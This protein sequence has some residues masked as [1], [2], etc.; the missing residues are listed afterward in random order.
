MRI[1]LI[2]LILC[3]CAEISIR[4]MVPA[5][6]VIYYRSEF[7][8][9]WQQ[10]FARKNPELAVFGPFGCGNPCTVTYNIGGLI[11]AF[12]SMANMI[13][14]KGIGLNIDGTCI[15]ACVRM[16]DLARPYACITPRAEFWVH[17]AYRID[18]GERF[19][20]PSSDDINAWV[21][22]KGGYPTD[23]YL[24]IGYEDAQRFWPKC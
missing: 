4:I 17:K 5:G 23:D 20:P 9:A 13:W 14:L 24:K 2:R 18:N 3:L 6:V 16:A 19:D 22:G 11:Y 7:L 21:A 8:L 1:F 15:S 12:E 10:H